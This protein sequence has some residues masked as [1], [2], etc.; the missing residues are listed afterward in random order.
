MDLDGDMSETFGRGVFIS[1]WNVYF[2]SDGWWLRHW[3]WDRP[4]FQKGAH[5][6]CMHNLA[7]F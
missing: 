3:I 5:T 6:H 1:N 7:I 4:E 2:Q